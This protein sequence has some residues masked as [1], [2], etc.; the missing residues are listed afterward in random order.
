LGCSALSTDTP[1]LPISEWFVLCIELRPSISPDRVL[2]RLEA[3]GLHD[4]HRDACRID[5]KR[6][7]AVV[8]I[9][10]Q[11]SPIDGRRV[12]ASRFE[13]GSRRDVQ[14]LAN[15]SRELGF[16]YR[17]IIVQPGLSK[18]KIAPAFLEVLGATE[19]FLQETFSMPL[20]VIAS[21]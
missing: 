20:E 16:S 7:L 10:P 8:V 11:L 17:V 3:D 1:P 14:Q 4:V 6:D 21:A 2:I 9:R 19:T 13:R 5:L 12:G 15:V 18:A